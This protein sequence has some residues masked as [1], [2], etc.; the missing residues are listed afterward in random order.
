[1]MTKIKKQSETNH[2]ISFNVFNTNFKVQVPN[3][4]RKNYSRNHI[5]SFI[6]DL[7]TEVQFE[8]FKNDSSKKVLLFYRP[9]SLRGTVNFV[10]AVEADE[11]LINLK[12][13]NNV[14]Q[15]IDYLFE[16]EK[17]LNFNV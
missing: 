16:N 12:S 8:M 5:K 10:F 2:Y 1:M 13:S 11:T 17:N 6:K 3:P 14:S 7:I 9:S 4:N 15:M